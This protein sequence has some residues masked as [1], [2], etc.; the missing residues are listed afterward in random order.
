MV[1]TILFIL[2][3]F[4]LQSALCR[5]VSLI[6]FLQVGVYAVTLVLQKLKRPHKRVI[7]NPEEFSK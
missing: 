7:V 6:A 4:F 3:A 2:H 1:I 5:L